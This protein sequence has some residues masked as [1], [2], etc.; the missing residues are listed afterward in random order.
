[1]RHFERFN[2]PAD[3]LRRVFLFASTA[4]SLKLTSLRPTFVTSRRSYNHGPSP[5]NRS[6]TG[7]MPTAFR[8]ISQPDP[9]LNIAN[10]G[11]KRK[12]DDKPEDERDENIKAFRVH[13]AQPDNTIGE[14]IPLVDALNARLRDE[15][16]RFTQ[17]LRVV[18]E[19][20]ARIV[21]PLC[22][23]Y[24]K[25]L[26]RDKELARKKSAKSTKTE[27]KQLEINWTVG[28]ND[29][30]HRMGRLKEFLGKGWRVEVIIGST[31]KRGWGGKR[32]DNQALA[33]SLVAKIRNAALE[34]E[35]SKQRTEMKGKLGEEV[36][37]SFEGPHRRAVDDG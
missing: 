21:Y 34:V 19:P 23:Y 1:M 14:P 27:Q 6:S 29:L 22:R 17:Y 25:Q 35:G 24:D 31:R 2:S 37:L 20:D 5:V 13:I 9:K 36:S 26:E 3:A 7:R 32:T 18:R 12:G 16:G 11:P 33:E 28:D 30:G 15:K 10:F 8:S 4:P